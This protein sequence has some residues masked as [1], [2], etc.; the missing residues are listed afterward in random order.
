MATLIIG[1]TGVA[2]GDALR[3]MDP[4]GEIEEVDDAGDNGAAKDPR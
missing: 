4:F 2:P 3:I 1:E